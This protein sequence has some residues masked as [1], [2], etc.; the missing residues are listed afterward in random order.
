MLKQGRKKDVCQRANYCTF[1]QS[2]YLSGGLTPSSETDL[3]STA[4]GGE[5]SH[6]E[7]Y[8]IFL[9]R[10]REPHSYSIMEMA[11]NNNS[12]RRERISIMDDKTMKKIRETLSID[13]LEKVNG[14]GG[15]DGGIDAS[16]PAVDVEEVKKTALAIAAQFGVGI[17]IDFAEAM[18]VS[19]SEAESWFADP[20]VG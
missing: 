7:I 9:L 8:K 3:L 11:F 17:A 2:V 5:A 19:R 15:G 18:G 10:F 1:S 4:Y 6:T 14:G 16:F 13:V 12:D 20:Q